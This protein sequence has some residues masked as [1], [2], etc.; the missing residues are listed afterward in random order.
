MTPIPCQRHL[1]EIPDEIAY[2][3]CAYMSPLLRTVRETGERS[4]ARKSRPWEL[5]PAYFF[6]VLH[7][8]RTRF[9]TLIGA[10]PDDIA[11]IPAVSYGMATAAHNTQ[12]LPGKR[13]LLLDEEF[14][15]TIY[16][17]RARA[18]EAGAEAILLPRPRDDDWTRVVLEAI[19]ERTAAAALP[20]CHW[21]DGALLDLTTIAAR[22]RE[23]GAVLALDLTQTLG[24]M[25]FDLEGVRPDW[26]IVAAY[27]WLLGPYSVGFMYVAPARQGGRPIEHSW[28][29]REGAEDFSRLVHYR[30][31]FQPGARRYDVGE[32]SNFALMPMAT[33]GL[34]QLLAWGVGAIQETLSDMTA[35][36]VADAEP[37]GFSAVPRARRAG[38]YLGLRRTGGLP[39]GLPERLTAARVFASVRGDALRITPH[40]YNTEQDRLQLLEV[41]AA[42]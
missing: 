33:A 34:E 1:F 8:A 20:Q 30:E 26:L 42:R 31:R 41:L 27:K 17:W 15:S 10:A 29:A 19:D 38:H 13:V 2:F 16:A 11:V 9:A 36:I 35:A 7:E 24:A 40:L 32:P 5:V 39:A 3:N 14:P 28:M 21:T 4:V 23:V 12:L 6:E 25:P 18:A 37:L 22:L